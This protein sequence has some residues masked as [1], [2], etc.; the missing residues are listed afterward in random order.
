MLATRRADVDQLNRLA[1]DRFRQA[2]RLGPDLLET[3]GR[4]FAVGDEII[5][6]R[7]QPTLGVI[8]GTRATVTGLTA[9]GQGLTAITNDD[10]RQQIELTGR[11]VADGHVA[12]AYAITIHKAQGATTE[13]TFVL[14]DEHLYREAGYVALSRGRAGNDI[15]TTPGTDPDDDHHGR[16]PRRAGD[17][18]LEGLGHSRA[19][20]A[21]L[22]SEP[23][24]L[25]G[26][27]VGELEADRRRL[28]RAI[29]GRDVGREVAER[30]ERQLA[31]LIDQRVKALGSWALEH[32]RPEHLEML[33]QAP[34][35][36]DRQREW[37][38]AAGLL[39]AYH[40]RF[41]HPYQRSHVPERDTHHHYELQRTLKDVAPYLDRSQ[42]LEH[43]RHLDRDRGLGL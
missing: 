6:G 31:A 8:N 28:I 42:T 37:T 19:Q 9:D 17:R 13:R 34:R 36:P 3:A 2:G 14:A 43:I 29:T 7:N 33:G 18:L 25:P 10:R 15:Y 22:P 30:Q 1:R 12:H 40:E 11:Y 32:P 16:P 27:T 41:D 21:A 5:C 26:R 23:P 20:Q 39:S 24:R 38:R 4:G 35:Q